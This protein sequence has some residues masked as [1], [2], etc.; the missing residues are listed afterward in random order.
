M[1]RRALMRGDGRPVRRLGLRDRS[2][3]SARRGHHHVI[4]QVHR[5]VGRLDVRH[6]DLRFGRDRPQPL[7]LSAVEADLIDIIDG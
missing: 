1:E 5:G 6:D 4:D 7:A 2:I 3:G